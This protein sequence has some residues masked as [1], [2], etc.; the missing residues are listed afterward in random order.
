MSE[1]RQSYRRY[2]GGQTSVKDVPFDEPYLS[3]TFKAIV[4]APNSCEDEPLSPALWSIV[5]W[6]IDA[7]KKDLLPYDSVSYNIHIAASNSDGII[8]DVHV[9]AIARVLTV[10][11]VDRQWRSRFGTPDSERSNEVCVNTR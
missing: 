9:G 10:T 8:E 3:Y 11:V 7:K 1:R 4:M 6:R 5:P 2:C